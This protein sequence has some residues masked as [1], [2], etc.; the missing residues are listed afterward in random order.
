MVSMKACL[1]EQISEKIFCPKCRSFCQFQ[2]HFF[3]VNWSTPDV[4]SDIKKPGWT[5]F[6]HQFPDISKISPRCAP[7]Y[8]P[9]IPKTSPRFSLDIPHI[10][11]I[12]PVITFG[13][14]CQFWKTNQLTLC[15]NPSPFLAMPGVWNY[16]Y[17]NSSLWAGIESISELSKMFDFVQ[18]LLFWRKSSWGSIVHVPTLMYIFAFLYKG[19]FSKYLN[20]KYP[21]ELSICL[22]IW[23]LDGKHTCT[24][25]DIMQSQLSFSP[26]LTVSGLLRKLAFL[27]ELPPAKPQ[28]LLH[29]RR[30]S[31][32]RSQDGLDKRWACKPAHLPADH[33]Q[34]GEGGAQVREHE[35]EEAELCHLQRLKQ[36]QAHKLGRT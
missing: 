32:T 2:H 23:S 9:D 26:L 1:A 12:S 36:P 13:G 5:L 7:R 6:E 21:F 27:F 31:S 24:Y 4:H 34:L 35:E 10:W 28:S 19:S 25:S 17:W 3:L 29:H 22:N 18:M 11:Y 14:I 8:L 30:G 16:P 33:R 20:C 15:L